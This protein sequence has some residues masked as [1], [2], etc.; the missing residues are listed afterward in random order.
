MLKMHQKPFGGRA[1][2]RPAGELKRLRPP[3]RNMGPTCKGR[4]REGRKESPQPDFLA[5]PLQLGTEMSYSKAH[6]Y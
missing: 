1:P 2:P 6:H 5:T 4:G 3:S